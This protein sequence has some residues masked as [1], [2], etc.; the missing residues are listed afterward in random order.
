MSPSAPGIQFAVMDALETVKLHGPS[1]DA[2]GA[3]GAAVRNLASDG[4]TAIIAAC[5]EVSLVLERHPP[6]LPWL[7]PLQ[8]L[9]EA[10]VREAIGADAGLKK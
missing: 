1:E 3:L 7:D 6:D 2:Y 4:A 10:L 8:I 9:A 5:T